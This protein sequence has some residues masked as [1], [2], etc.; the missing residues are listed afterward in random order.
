MNHRAT[1]QGE[2]ERVC[3]YESKGVIKKREGGGRRESNEKRKRRRQRNKE[4]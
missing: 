1:K 2:S 4:G 3:E